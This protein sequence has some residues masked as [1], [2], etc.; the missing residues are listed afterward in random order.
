MKRKI[1]LL[2]V[3]IMMI[4]GLLLGTTENVA[5]YAGMQPTGTL[6]GAGNGFGNGNNNGGTGSA[7]VGTACIITSLSLSTEP[8]SATEQDSL[9]FMVEEEKLARDVYQFL[10]D[11]WGLAV[12]ANISRSEQIH[13]NAVITLIDRYGLTNPVSAESG[14]FSNG[15]LQALYTQL[16]SR[17]SQSLADALLVGGAIEEIDIRDLQSRLTNVTH[18]DI[19]QVF[20]NLL[21]GSYTHLQAFADEYE[22]QTGNVYAPQYLDSMVYQ[23]AIE[24]T[25]MAGGPAA[26]RGTGNG[27]YGLR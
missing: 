13:M 26:S 10:S 17:G 4:C 25:P 27:K 2:T 8:L 24:A 15:D 11:K 19:S 14:I 12:F 23:Q 3:A 6:N 9:L 20:N 18:S 5:A 7:C 16:T 21:S 1:T 22:L